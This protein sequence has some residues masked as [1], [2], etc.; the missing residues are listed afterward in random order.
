M[1]NVATDFYSS[2]IPVAPAEGGP[3][4]GQ[5]YRDRYEQLTGNS[6]RMCPHCKL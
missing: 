4:R 3:S 2:Q 1:F 6:L 5:D